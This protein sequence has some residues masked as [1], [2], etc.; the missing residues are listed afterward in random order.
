MC[1]TKLNAKNLIREINKHALSVIN[2]HI[3]VVQFSPQEFKDL[4]TAIRQILIKHGI[5]MQ[6][7]SKERLYLSRKVD[8]SGLLS[9]VHKLEHMLLQMRNCFETSKESSI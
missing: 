9:I 7:A 1:L 2:Y 4:D 6:S 3:G 5:H 8:G